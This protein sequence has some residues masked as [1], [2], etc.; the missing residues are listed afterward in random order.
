MNSIDFNLEEQ[1]KF[2]GETGL[3][4]YAHARAESILR[5][6][7]DVTIPTDGAKILIQKLGRL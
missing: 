3:V 1:L 5:K 4:Q 7:A 6:A 2:E